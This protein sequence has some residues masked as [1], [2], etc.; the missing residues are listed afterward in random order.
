MLRSDFCDYSNAYIIVKRDITVTNPNNAKINKVVV[1]KNNTPFI[2]CISKIKGIKIDNAEDLDVVMPMYNLLEYSKNYRKTIGSLWNYYRDQPSNPLWTNSE[3]FK[4]KTSITGNT[5]NVD[6]DDDN[7]D[8]NKVGKN[9]TEIVIPL[10]Y[11][12]NFWRSLN[13]PLINCEVE[14]ILTWSKNCVLADM[15]VANNPPTGLEFQIK[16]TKL[17]APV[18]TLSKENDIKLLENLKSGFK[19]TIKSNK[20]RL[21]MTI[22]NNNNNLNYLIDPTFANVKKLFVLSFKRIEEKN[23]KNDRRDSFS[24]Y[25]VP[26]VQIKDFYILIDGKSFFGLPVEHEEETYGKIIEM[27]NNNDYT[28]SNLLDFVYYKENHKLIAIDISKPTKMKDPQQINFIG[29]IEGQNNG[30]TTF[31]IIEKSE[32][33]IFEFSQ[34]SVNIFCKWR[35]KRL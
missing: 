19:R 24:Y 34:H 32:E 25:Y 35:P 30:V 6:D 10:K 4:Y 33:T 2:N 15:T 13:I 3:S 20:Y 28:G 21:Q 12:S 9:E 8:A 16:D 31:F 22:Q 14:L 29:K 7:Y 1:F 5:Y 23:V 26:K 27:S 18:V 17:S 11:L